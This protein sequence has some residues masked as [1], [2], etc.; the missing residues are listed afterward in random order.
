MPDK[1]NEIKKLEGEI[2][3]CEK[4]PLFKTRTKAVPGEG[5]A[6]A[7][8]VFIGEA[9]GREEDR[10]GRPFCGRAGKLLDEL[11]KKNEIERKNVF[12]TSVV[13]CRPPKNRLP[14]NKEIFPCRSFWEK[15]ID[16]INP[17]KIILLGKTAFDEVVGLGEMK[18]CRGR[19]LKIKNRFYLPLY[20]PAAALRSP[21]KVKK[22]LEKDFT[23]IKR[24]LK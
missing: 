10:C 12:I 18:D 15:Q 4:C 20:H 9:P 13:K 16:I 8:I 22:I 1:K 19:W 2:R 24:K 11:L 3:K 6:A 14:K 7:E 5:S 17:E 21:K 23:E